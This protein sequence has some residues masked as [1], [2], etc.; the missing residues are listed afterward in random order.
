[1][2]TRTGEF[3]F[4]NG[5]TIT[6]NKSTLS[7]INDAKKDYRIGTEV[8]SFRKD[9]SKSHDCRESYIKELVPT[10]IDLDFVNAKN[11]WNY[12]NSYYNLELSEIA[13]YQKSNNMESNYQ[14]AYHDV[15][16]VLNQTGFEETQVIKNRIATFNNETIVNCK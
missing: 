1:M 10:Y 13:K 9:Y 15:W 8:S 6:V 14:I 12:L 11:V 2:L 5:E 3:R 7:Y 16:E 4:D